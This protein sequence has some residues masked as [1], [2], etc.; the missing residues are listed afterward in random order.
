ML[1]GRKLMWL[2]PFHPFFVF[3]EG[4]TGRAEKVWASVAFRSLAYPSFARAR[5]PSGAVGRACGTPPTFSL[6]AFS[7][8]TLF[9]LLIPSPPVERKRRELDWWS[10]PESSEESLWRMDPV[11]IHR[12]FYCAS[13]RTNIHPTGR[14]KP[15]TVPRSQASPVSRWSRCRFSEVVS[16]S[17]L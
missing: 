13:K 5:F 2:T 14:L 7:V 11:G 6:T 3:V 12:L 15:D 9:S 17:V 8:L 1:F 4:S 16:I 10:Y